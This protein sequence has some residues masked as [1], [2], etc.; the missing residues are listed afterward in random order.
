MT[1]FIKIG[2][3]EENSTRICRGMANVGRKGGNVNEP[4]FLLSLTA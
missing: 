4:G 2:K 3:R 1:G